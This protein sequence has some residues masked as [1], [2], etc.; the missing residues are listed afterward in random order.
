MEKKKI[1]LIDQFDKEKNLSDVFDVFV[2]KI[3][4]IAR[5]LQHDQTFNSKSVNYIMTGINLDFQLN[6]IITSRSIPKKDFR[7][8]KRIASLT[9]QKGPFKKKY[10]KIINDEEIIFK[11]EK[12]LLKDLEEIKEAETKIHIGKRL[13]GF[14]DKHR[15]LY[16]VFDSLRILMID[17]NN[18]LQAKNK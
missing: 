1:N 2:T 3:D 18:Q 6:T 7:L 9:L 16:F 13:E 11:G 17:F 12:V 14:Y 15:N 5:Q 4:K 8:K 10:L